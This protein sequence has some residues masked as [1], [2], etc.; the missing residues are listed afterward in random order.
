M[1][2]AVCNTLCALQAAEGE[3]GTLVLEQSFDEIYHN[4]TALGDAECRF[5]LGR[6]FVVG[7]TDEDGNELVAKDINQELPGP[8]PFCHATR[9]THYTAVD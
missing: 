8:S 7:A 1:P 2:I 3:N 6:C 5:W 4:A 9:H